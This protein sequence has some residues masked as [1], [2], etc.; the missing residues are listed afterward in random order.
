MF[1]ATSFMQ[2]PLTIF[3]IGLTLLV[4]FF[5]YFA[6]DV[7]RRKRN[8]G[9]VLATR[10]LMADLR[11]ADPF[12]QGGGRGFSKADRSRFLDSLDRALRG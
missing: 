6:T 12:R 5:W 8:I 10:N 7:D 3:V 9:S 1:I 4:L 2:D 11:S